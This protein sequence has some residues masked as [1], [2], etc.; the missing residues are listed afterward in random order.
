MGNN[1]TIPAIALVDYNDLTQWSVIRIPT[2]K[3][4]FNDIWGESTVIVNGEKVLLVSRSNHSTLKALVSSSNDYGKT[5]SPLY[6]SNLPMIDSRTPLAGANEYDLWAYPYA[7]EWDS[8]L[9]VGFYMNGN[10]S[11]ASGAAAYVT[12]PIRNLE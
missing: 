8:N 5:W 7:V 10:K 1:N 9:T 11:Y 3:P 6:T 12:I 2:I 4:N